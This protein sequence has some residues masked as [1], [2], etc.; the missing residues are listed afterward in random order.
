MTLDEKVLVRQ[1]VDGDFNFIINSWLRSYADGS[2]FCKRIRNDVFYKYHHIAVTRMLSRPA[3]KVLVACD[4]VD[5]SVIL[6]YL[7]F[8]LFEGKPLVNYIYVKS[9]FR[10]LGVASSLVTSAGI[11]LNMAVFSHWTKPTDALV[12]KF[13]GLTYN[14]Y[15][16]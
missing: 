12:K 14:P 3:S 10:R 13:P 2:H 6:G 4:P 7:S 8:D 5:P 11:D 16:I 9:A 1:M 15:L